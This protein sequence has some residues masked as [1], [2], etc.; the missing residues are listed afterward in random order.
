MLSYN[1]PVDMPAVI[2]RTWSR[3]WLRGAAD[4][5][6]CIVTDWLEV[7]VPGA[8]ALCGSHCTCLHRPGSAATIHAHRPDI[9][10]ELRLVQI[11]GMQ[12][13][14]RAGSTLSV[15]LAEGSHALLVCLQVYNQLDWHRTAATRLEAVVQALER[16]SMDMVRSTP[17]LRSLW[18]SR[19]TCMTAACGAARLLWPP[20]TS[21]STLC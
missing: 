16:S 21:T 17:A 2:S 15:S 3:R 12:D 10:R 5:Q 6:G 19:I 9:R 20:L 18:Q 7:R 11:D 13:R 14:N 8:T 1:T 4:F